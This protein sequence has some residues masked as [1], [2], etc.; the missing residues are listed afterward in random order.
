MS[1]PMAPFRPYCKLQGSTKEKATLCSM[2]M[3]FLGS[4]A[5]GWEGRSYLVRASQDLHWHGE[6]VLVTKPTFANT[7]GI[8]NMSAD[9][10]KMPA[11]KEEG[12]GHV[13][14]CRAHQETWGLLSTC[15]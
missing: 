8:I 11:G 6:R 9:P 7:A 13:H 4:R 3:V 10:H 2:A 15:F 12:A 1:I 5:E 14:T